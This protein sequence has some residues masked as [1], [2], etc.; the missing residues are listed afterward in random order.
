M[1]RAISICFPLTILLLLPMLVVGC[2]AQAGPEA[3]PVVVTVIETVPVEVTRQVEATR[4]VEVTRQVII[5]QLIEQII[6]PTPEGPK[7]TPSPSDLEKPLTPQPTLLSTT[8]IGG[9]TTPKSSSAVP[10]FI[11]NQTDDLLTLNLYGPQ[12][13]L[14]LNIGKDE[15]RKTFLKEGEYSYEIRRDDKLVY[16]GSFVINNFDKHEFFLRENKAV[17]WIP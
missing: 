16:V 3:S 4:L 12:L 15:I 13:L 10:F 5:T 2:N 6:T 8:N 17:L 1:P 11:E 9:S 14:T 7:A